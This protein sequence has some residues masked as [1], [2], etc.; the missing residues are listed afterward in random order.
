MTLPKLNSTPKYEMNIPSTGETI[1]FRPFLIKEEKS[2]LIAAE[3]G[4][5]R[6][7]LLSLLDTLK[8][9]CDAEIN[10]NKLSTFDV[11]YMFLKLRAK[12]VG[13]TTK[14][15]VKCNNCGHTNTLD[16]NIEEIEIK[17]PETEKLVQL[18]DK[19]QVEL[20][21]P[22]FSDVL[23]S[24]LGIKST[25]SEQLFSMM[26]FVFKTVITDDERINLKEVSKEELTDFIESMDSRQFSKVK[27]FIQEI[28]KLK[29]SYDIEC[30]GCKENIK[31]D[32]EGLANFL[33]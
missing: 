20:D 19:I 12:S 29:H 32:M 8:A 21:Y 13:E 10:E 3:S 33:S 25:A 9:C 6:T 31:G 4:D 15:G 30:G 24:D 27:D 14:I 11:E 22:T 18:T 7:I 5:N 17:K 2:M 1:R 26:N 23:N 28:P 16:V